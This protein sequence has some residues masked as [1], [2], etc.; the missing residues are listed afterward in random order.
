MMQ[1][2]KDVV[3]TVRENCLTFYVTATEEIRKRLP[4][5]NTFLSKLQVFASSGSL[6]NT[7]RETSFNDVLRP[8]DSTISS[9]QGRLII[10]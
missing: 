4:V 7:D 1:G 9:F 10:Y 8:E 3:T 2:H 5:N 6:F